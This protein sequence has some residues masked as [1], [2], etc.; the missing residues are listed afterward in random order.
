MLRRP[1]ELSGG[2]DTRMAAHRQSMEPLHCDL[3]E[4]HV[5]H[6]RVWL[7]APDFTPFALCVCVWILYGTRS[8]YLYLGG[9]RK[10]NEEQEKIQVVFIRLATPHASATLTRL[11]PHTPHTLAKVY[12]PPHVSIH[13]PRVPPRGTATT[14]LT[15]T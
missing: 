10:T 3:R 15:A 4:C 8:C 13:A 5:T 14:V 1:G 6:V 12:A 7:A 9:I 11:T 2:V